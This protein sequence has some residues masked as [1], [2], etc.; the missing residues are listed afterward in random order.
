MTTQEEDIQALV[1][2][3]LTNS[4]AKVYLSLVITGKT[5]GHAIWKN[6]GVAR[7]D[8]YRILTELQE[9]GLVEK[10]IA[11]PTEYKPTSLK[12]GLA[13]LLKDKAHEYEAAEIRTKDLLQK[14]QAYTGEDTFEEYQFSLVPGREATKAK[15]KAAFN[16]TQKSID[17]IFYWKGF[18]PFIGDAAVWEKDLKKGVKLRMIVYR[19]P[20]E[21]NSPD[22]MHALKKEYLKVRCTSRPPPASVTI[23]DGEKALITTSPAPNPLESSSLWLRNTGF[24]VIVED[25]FE[26]LWRSLGKQKAA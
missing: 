14:L 2:L 7:Q 16:S 26:R 21:K 22:I 4:Q 5:K 19:P 10:I 3:G 9:K 1:G 8:V 15:F 11:T 20:E 6:S 23:F 24:V 17:A 18:V 25:Y 12:E 13:I